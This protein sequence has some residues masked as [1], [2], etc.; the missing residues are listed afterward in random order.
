MIPLLGLKNYGGFAAQMADYLASKVPDTKLSTSTLSVNDYFKLVDQ[1]QQ[2]TIPTNVRREVANF[3][4]ALAQPMLSAHG[5]KMFS[6]FLR[7]LVSVDS[8]SRAE[9]SKNLALCLRT[10]AN[11]FEIWRKEYRSNLVATSFLLKWISDKDASFARKSEDFQETL[12]HFQS[13]NDAFSPTAKVPQGLDS[14]I[15][16]CDTLLGKD[17]PKKKSS[18]KLKN[19]NYLLLIAL[20]SLVYYDTRVY[21]DGQFANSRLGQAAEQSGLTAKAMELHQRAHPYLSQAEDRFFHLRDIVYLK[22]GEL[23]RR[24]QP[25]LTQAGEGLV[26]LR[27]V[28]YRKGE[29]LYPGIWAEADKKYQAALVVIKEQSAFVYAKACQ[30]AGQGMDA[31][32]KNWER[33]LEWSAVYRKQ[34]SVH[35]ENAVELSG[36]YYQQARQLT[37]EIIEKEQVQHALKYTYDMYHKALHAVGLCSH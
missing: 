31:G 33:F 11:S 6:Q 18:S 35:A 25:Y 20:I 13:I 24:A 7:R 36:V 22:G 27:D 17:Q 5:S 4:Q 30:Y 12:H 14:C 37:A 34:L 2:G 19:L 21:G 23:Y 1:V 29:E 9:I 26:Q 8:S 10:D 16:L 15:Q 28:V 3:V 32:A